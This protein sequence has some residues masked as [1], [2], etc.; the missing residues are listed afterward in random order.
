MGGAQKS[1]SGQTYTPRALGQ[2]EDVIS[3]AQG[4]AANT[5]YNP[6]TAMRVAGLSPLQTQGY[7]GIAGMQGR[8]DPAMQQ[9][10][11]AAG[12]VAGGVSPDQVQQW[13]SPYTQAVINATMAQAQQQQGVDGAGAAATGRSAPECRGQSNRLQCAGR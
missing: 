4:I 5:Q 1:T 10:I 9:A 13:Q 11:S 7:S 12:N 8:Y 3:G 2:F 6:A